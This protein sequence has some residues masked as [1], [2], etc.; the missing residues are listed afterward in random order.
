MKEPLALNSDAE[1]ALDRARQDAA[2]AGRSGARPEDLLLALCDPG[3]VAA[4]VLEVAGIDPGKVRAALEFI[5][6]DA[7]LFDGESERRTIAFAS[8]EAFL[9]GDQEVGSEHLLLGVI[10]QPNSIAAGVL[11]SL[12]LP[13]DRARAAVRRVR[14]EDVDLDRLRQ[15]DESGGSWRPL[16]AAQV[17]DV[18]RTEVDLLERSVIEL[19]ETPLQRVV[20]IGQTSVAAGI[21]VEL[22]AL[23]IREGGAILYWRARQE[24][25]RI[26]G[27]RVLDV[28][29]RGEPAS[30]VRVLGEPEF[31]VHDDAGTR[32]SVFPRSEGGGDRL[33]KGEAEIDPSPPSGATHMRIEIERFEARDF[34]PGIAARWRAE[35]VSGPWRFEFVLT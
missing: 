33:W 20:A 9:L 1:A 23:E 8:E 16:I 24:G 11:E 17:D 6:H 18:A 26:S 30:E 15:A 22:I 35:A 12:D 31:E 19:E 28:P 13:L 10:R 25:N 29:N 14:G 7:P 27:E 32:Y 34:W 2:R 21:S 3:T 5:T 4:N